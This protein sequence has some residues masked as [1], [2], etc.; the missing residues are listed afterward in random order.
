MLGPGHPEIRICLDLDVSWRPLARRPAVH[1]GT[2]RSPL[3]TPE[4]AV[5]FARAVARRAGFR[6]A[7]VMGYEGQIAGL[8][9]A[10]HGAPLKAALLRLAQS[11][12]AVELNAR[13]AEAV[14]LIRGLTSLEFVNGGGTG[15]LESTAADKSVT[16]LAAG[17]GL[18]GPTLFDSYRRFRPRPHIVSSRLPRIRKRMAGKR[19]NPVIRFFAPTGG[20]CSAMPA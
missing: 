20:S 1:I 2:R 12:S 19:R 17:S 9:D 15:S 13:R 18:V 14:R 3:H 11:R 7:G 5:A 4:Q 16:E 6:L 10:P 8:G